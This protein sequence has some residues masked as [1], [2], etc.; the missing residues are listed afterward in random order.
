MFPILLGPAIYIITPLV[1]YRQVIGIAGGVTYIYPSPIDGMKLYA[2]LLILAFSEATF[3]Q[4]S[5]DT[6]ITRS[7]LDSLETELYK[8]K[9]Q[10]RRLEYQNN[11]Y[12]SLH[13]VDSLVY[14]KDSVIISYRAKDG[15]LLK[16][17]KKEYREDSSVSYEKVEFCNSVGQ[18]EFVEQWEHAR[19]LDQELE[20]VFSWI[21]YSYE[22]FEYDSIGRVI[23]WI[24]FYPSISKS[25]ARTFRFEYNAEGKR[26]F[27]RTFIA[28]ERFWD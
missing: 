3:A 11:V 9:D 22:R 13:A 15:K 10:C 18:T 21:I 6:T 28:K 19:S 14:G 17:H 23:T 5:A 2:L 12:A 27:S 25:K 26:T 16:R 8:L 1:I 24:K 4:H 7:Q 20:Q